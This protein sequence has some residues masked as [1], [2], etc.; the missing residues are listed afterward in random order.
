MGWGDC[1]TDSDGRPIGYI[2]EAT[3]DHPECS[4]VINRGLYYACGD[5]HGSTEDGCE[6]YFCDNHISGYSPQLCQEC[7]KVYE[8]SNQLC[9][10][11]G[12]VIKEGEFKRTDGVVT[13]C[14]QCYKECLGLK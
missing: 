6:L 3:C 10:D 13:L 5:M 4:K 11:C 9:N 2:F 8:E 1:G 12:D 14:E 7:M